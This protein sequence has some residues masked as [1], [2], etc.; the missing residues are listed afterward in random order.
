[1]IACSISRTVAVLY[2]IFQKRPPAKEFLL[3]YRLTM[4]T[5]QGKFEDCSVGDVITFSE[6]SR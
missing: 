2:V 4:T 1:M 6:P 3:V 5:K